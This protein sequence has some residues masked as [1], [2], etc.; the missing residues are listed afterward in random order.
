MCVVMQTHFF[1]VEK[2][3][4]EMGGR[5]DTHVNKAM[6]MWF[7]WLRRRPFNGTKLLFFW[8]GKDAEALSINSESLFFSFF[9]LVAVTGVVPKT[10]PYDFSLFDSLPVQKTHFFLLHVFVWFSTNPVWPSSGVSKS[11]SPSF[12]RML[13]S[14]WV[15]S[16]LRVF[17]LHSSPWKER[18]QQMIAPRHIINP[19]MHLLPINFPVETSTP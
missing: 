2:N 19:H 12:F 13:N 11:P 8:G 17:S 10:T 3:H 5:R 6:M 9:S 16:H 1:S 15:E 4:P 14:T 18:C 7:L